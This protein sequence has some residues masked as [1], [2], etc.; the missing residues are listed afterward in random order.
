LNKNEEVGLNYVLP[1]IKKNLFHEIVCVDGGSTD[2]SLKVL[3]NHGFRVLPQVATGRGEAFKQALNY[4]SKMG[5]EYIIF[6]STDGNENP[7]DLP[8]FIESIRLAPDLIIASRMLKE[9]R[10]EEDDYFWRPRKWAN[11]LFA[12]L[13]WLIFSRKTSDYI[14]DPINGYR[15][16]KVCSWT[17]VQ[18]RSSG[19]S[20]EYESSIKAYKHKMRTIEFPTFEHNRIGGESSAT[21]FKTTKDLLK[22]LL[23]EVLDSI[24]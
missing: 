20:I 13:A 15:A 16:F 17:K 11:K 19:F 24:K 8:L 12:Y 3:M 9:S 23:F 18:F 21:A 14:S 22:I 1:K 7:A 2:D 4:A 5:H 6:F 10:N